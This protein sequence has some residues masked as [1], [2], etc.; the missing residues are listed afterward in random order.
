MTTPSASASKSMRT[1]AMM[2]GQPIPGPKG[3]STEVLAIQ[4]DG[5]TVRVVRFELGSYELTDQAKWELRGV[6]NTLRGSPQKIMVKGYAV[7][8]EGEGENLQTSDLAFFRAV[9]VIEY[10]ASLGLSQDFFDINVA[11][12]TLPGR[13]V[14]PPGTD[15]QFAGASAEI[16][17]L[18]QTLR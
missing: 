1:S 7:P 5:T 15:P 14:L 8:A 18:N 6:L 11:P 17:L 12:G 2:G 16:I 9:S 4:T 10:F 3:E 13:N